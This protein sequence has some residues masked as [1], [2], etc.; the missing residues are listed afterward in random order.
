MAEPILFGYWRSSAAYRVRIAAN[1]KG[2]SYAAAFVHLRRGEQRGAAN[3]AR[4]PAGLVPTWSED[5]FQLTQSLAILEYLD[6]TNPRPPLLPST[7]RAR[8]LAREIALVVV[9]DIHPVG[10]LRVLEKLTTDFGA[11]ATQRAAWNRHWIGLGFAAIEARLAQTAGAHAIGDQITLADVCLVPQVY[12]A[13][14]FE[15]DLAA[16]PTIERVDAVARALVPFQQA[17]PEAQFD[18]E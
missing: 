2:I 12:N 6:E 1:V 14:R 4:N 17:S 16:Y 11:E 5:D 8:A 13:R 18:A 3:L 9:C 15:L 7:P 10:N